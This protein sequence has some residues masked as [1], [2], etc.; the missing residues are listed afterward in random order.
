MAK[1]DHDDRIEKSSTVF[2]GS[3]APEHVGRICRSNFH[4]DRLAIGVSKNGYAREYCE[5]SSNRLP[6]IWKIEASSISTNVL[7]TR[8]LWWRKRGAPVSETPSG[9]RG[10]SSWQWQ[11]TL[12][13]LSPYT[14]C[15]LRCMKSPLFERLF[16]VA[17]FTLHPSDSSV[18]ERYDGAPL[19]RQ[20]QQD[21][22][23][24]ISPHKVNGVKLKT[25]N[26]RPLRRY[27]KRWPIE[28]L[29]AWMHYF[30]RLVVRSEYHAENFLGFVYL[31]CMIIL[32]RRGF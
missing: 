14:L 23:E 28:P 17:S 27:A 30:R 9:A 16:S 6:R 13:F 22:I 20:L 25:Q 11:T 21:G 32:L 2:S 7:S 5:G 19:D 10:R 1:D 3:S 24:V 26:G 15:L 29:F 12:V 31:A 8:P 4:H 18:I